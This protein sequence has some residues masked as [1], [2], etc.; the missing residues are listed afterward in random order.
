MNS[1]SKV[2]IPSFDTLKGI[3]D[4]DENVIKMIKRNSW[5]LS[6]CGVENVMVNIELLRNQGVPETKITNYLIWHSRVFTQDADKFRKIVEKTKEMGFNP[7]YTTFLVAIH[8]LASMTEVNWKNKMDVY[9]RW[10]W[11]EAQ[12]QAAF[13]RNPRCMM[14]SEKKI[15]AIMSFLVNE[16]GYDSSS[17][18]ESPLIFDRS[19]KGRIIPRCSV[20]KILVSKGLI[21]EL[22]PLSAV[23][24]M[25][26][27]AFLEKF[28]LKYEQQVP[29]LMKLFK[30][31][32][33]PFFLGK[34]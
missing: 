1:F 11:S 24:A 34:D 4:S 22:I 28:V 6:T 15:M 3:L 17:A 30:V 2:I 18:A 16:M 26:D 23:S 12:I 5:I 14:A 19:L 21:K 13:R 20:T 29:G 33:I 9:K 7:L 27:E 8:A 32:S 31:R 25:I 10:G